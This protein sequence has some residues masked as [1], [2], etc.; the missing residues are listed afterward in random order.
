MGGWVEEGAG[1]GLVSMQQ[2]EHDIK[3]VGSPS[4]RRELAV[5][6]AWAI[7]LTLLVLF[8]AIP[9]AWLILTN[10]VSN[11]AEVRMD[12][13]ESLITQDHYNQTVLWF[14]FVGGCILVSIA[15]C[16]LL[17]ASLF[18]FTKPRKN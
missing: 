7:F 10:T 15:L 2:A 9:F 12:P 16:I 6:L 5:R 3:K 18:V 4:K 13:G 11:I 14:L 17:W 1:E 8:F